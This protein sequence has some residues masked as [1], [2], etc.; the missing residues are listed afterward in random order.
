MWDML[1]YVVYPP[2][3]SSQADLAAAVADDEP[4][5]V[6]AAAFRVGVEVGIDER[7]AV[8]GPAM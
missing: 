2:G 7:A 5:S 8:V 4:T 1:M 3:Y 6:A